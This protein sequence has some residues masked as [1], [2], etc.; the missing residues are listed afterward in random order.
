MKICKLC[1]KPIGEDSPFSDY[2][3]SEC[4]RKAVGVHGMEKGTRKGSGFFATILIIIVGI[5]FVGIKQCGSE[6]KQ[7]TKESQDIE[8]DSQNTNDKTKQEGN[9]SAETIL[10]EE[11]TV[12]GKY[13]TIN[14]EAE[15]EKESSYTLTKSYERYQADVDKAIEMLKR[16]K[17]VR[18]IADSTVLLKEDIRKLKRK[19][20]NDE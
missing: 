14:N 5:F 2:C 19:L 11:D 6:K 1:P 8:L 16:G 12:N 3:S 13:E 9:I 7:I 4:E 18:V 20:R 10:S 15:V 17:S